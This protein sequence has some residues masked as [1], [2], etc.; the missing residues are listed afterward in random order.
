MILADE[1]LYS[2]YYSN[3]YRDTLLSSLLTAERQGEDTCVLENKYIVLG[4]W[5][6][7]LENYYT[8]AFNEEGEPIT[9]DYVC[10]TQEQAIQL[11]A[12]LKLARGNNKYPVPT[13]FELGIWLDGSGYWDDGLDWLDEINVS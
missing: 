10:L 11:L 4:E 9:P 2:L 13:M 8:T 1:I 12:K 5:I 3:K 7:I 6:R